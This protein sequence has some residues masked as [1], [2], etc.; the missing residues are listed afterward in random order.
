[1]LVNRGNR[2]VVLSVTQNEGARFSDAGY[3][4]LVDK[5]IDDEVLAICVGM[6]KDIP[7]EH[8]HTLISKA[9]E[10]VFEKLVASNPA[11]ACE[12]QQVLTDITGQETAVRPKG[13]PD[14]DGAKEQFE[15]LRR[16]GRPADWV[17]QEFAATGKFD[18]TVAALAILCRAPI[19]LVENAMDDRR[20]GNDLALLLAKA[21]GLSWGTV[22]Q[23][24]IL[25][26]GAGGLSPQ[27]IEA[28]RES[29]ER[30]QPATAQAVVRFYNERYAAATDFQQLEEQIREKDGGPRLNRFSGA[31]QR[32]QE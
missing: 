11:A 25:R 4:K 10:R 7:R 17:V 22:R 20:G 12:V 13:R 21:A 8:F 14:Y 27:A 28:A 18:E 32:S 31:T 6:R 24:C 5:S 3:G 19:E 2:D 15:A 16:L 29:F 1:M 30:L 26:E 9:S 23:I